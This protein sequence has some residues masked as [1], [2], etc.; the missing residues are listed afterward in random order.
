[1]QRGEY[2]QASLSAAG[3]LPL[4]GTFRK[5]GKY[6]GHL[7][8]FK[9]AYQG[10][11]APGGLGKILGRLERAGEKSLLEGLTQIDK[12]LDTAHS[13]LRGAT[14]ATVAVIDLRKAGKLIGEE[15]GKAAQEVS[16][17]ESALAAAKAEF[18]AV[19]KAAAAKTVTHVLETRA[20]VEA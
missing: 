1:Y 11:K 12:A 18:T 2:A 7:L 17:A 14:K 4:L 15:A 5:A 19:S 10:L 13:A 8:E 9:S 6:L 20:M 16:L 3:A